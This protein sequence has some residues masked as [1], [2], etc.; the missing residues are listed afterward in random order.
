MP[1]HYDIDGSVARFTIDNGRLNI[2]TGEMYEQLFVALS[3]FIADENLKVGIICGPIRATFAQAM[4]SSRLRGLVIRFR[5][6]PRPYRLYAV[7]SQSLQPPMAGTLALDFIFC[8][9]YLTFVLPLPRHDSAFP[10]SVIAWAA[11][12]VPAGSAGNYRTQS[13]CRCS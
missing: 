12:A 13:Q 2:M 1:I 4:T 8:W 3:R 5:A 10:R 11:P 6:G 9:C 7:T